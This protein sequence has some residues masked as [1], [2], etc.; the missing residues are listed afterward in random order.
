MVCLT[1]EETFFLSF[2]LAK[3]FITLLFGG[4]MYDFKQ[5]WFRNSGITENNDGCYEVKRELTFA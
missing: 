2:Q 4:N 3:S 1:R 5:D